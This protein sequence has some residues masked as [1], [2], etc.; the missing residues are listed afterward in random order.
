MWCWW[1]WP[2]INCLCGE[3]AKGRVGGVKAE[4]PL[5]ATT[6]SAPDVGSLQLVS[7]K[8][9]RVEGGASFKRRIWCEGKMKVEPVL[10]TDGPAEV[11]QG[12]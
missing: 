4:E 3:E 2:R 9:E 7:Y 6:K 5:L 11:H 10:T 12:W 8:D 1:K